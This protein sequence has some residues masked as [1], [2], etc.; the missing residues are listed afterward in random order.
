MACGL[1]HAHVVVN[2]IT[3]YSI[4]NLSNGHKTFLIIGDANLTG[5]VVLGLENHQ[6]DI[7]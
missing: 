3:W 1:A 6:E 2:E 7:L 4:C 5:T